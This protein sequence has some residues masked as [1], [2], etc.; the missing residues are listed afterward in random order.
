V[1]LFLLCFLGFLMSGWLG[2]GIPADVLFVAGCG[3][4]AWYAK[5]SDL[6]TVA[7]APPLAFFFACLLAKLISS[8]GGTSA[9]EGILVTLATS[10]PWLFA[11]TAL[12]IAIGLRRG[13]LGNLR[14][15]RQ[16]LQGNP[17]ERV[18]RADERARR[19]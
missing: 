2:S 5:P 7:V 13:L 14:E 4:M 6:L 8:S 18:A 11:G 12:T 17:G 15:L 9:A 19:R 1:G 3:A 16:G 10:A